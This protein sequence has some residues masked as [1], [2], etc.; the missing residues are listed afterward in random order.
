M[1]SCKA[2]LIEQGF[3]YP[4]IF[5]GKGENPVSLPRLQNVNFYYEEKKGRGKKRRPARRA[6]KKLK[7]TDP[8]K[9]IFEDLITQNFTRTSVMI[10][11]FSG[12]VCRADFLNSVLAAF[13]VT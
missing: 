5:K 4:C 8:R 7:N 12:F 3:S 6:G 10:G 1:R 13:S 2:N 9:P 11:I